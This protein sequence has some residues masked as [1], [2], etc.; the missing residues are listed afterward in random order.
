MHVELVHFLFLDHKHL[1]VHQSYFGIK[2]K[3]KQKQKLKLT[4][5]NI[6]ANLKPASSVDPQWVFKNLTAVKN[7]TLCSDWTLSAFPKAQS[8]QCAD[9]CCA[10]ETHS[11]QLSQLMNTQWIQQ[12]WAEI[13]GHSESRWGCLYVFKLIELA[14]WEQIHQPHQELTD[15]RCES[16]ESLTSWLGLD[17]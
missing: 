2:K 10:D 15:S 17:F 9:N 16:E 3:K 4:L 12:Q 11:S 14:N 8:C 1:L 7:T 6:W 5:Q 13:R